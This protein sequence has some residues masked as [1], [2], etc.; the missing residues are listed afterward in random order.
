[1]TF[2]DYV[3]SAYEDIKS[4]KIRGAGRIA[5]HAVKTLRMYISEMPEKINSENMKKII[6]VAKFLNSSRPTAISLKNSLRFVLRYSYR[7]ENYSS[8]LLKRCDMFIETA[9]TSL[10]KIGNIAE[11]RIKDGDTILTHCNSNAAISGIIKAHE[12]GKNIKVINTESRPAF[13]GRITSRVLAEKGLD[14][15]MIV[16]SAVRYHIPDVD[17]VMVGADTITSNGVVINKIGTSQVAAFAH[18]ARRPFL[19]CAETYKIS[20]ETLI[21]NLVSIEERPSN[22][23]IPDDIKPDGLKVSNPVFDATPPEYITGIVTEIG[24]ISPHSVYYVM[25]EKMGDIEDILRIGI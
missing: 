24:L 4:M 15:T 1:M 16:D 6:R 13:Q 25:K 8:D 18:E 22:E 7:E 12:K 5:I 10:E 17:I 9:K 2:P 20:P 3:K 21:G 11:E 14:V 19:V 23:V